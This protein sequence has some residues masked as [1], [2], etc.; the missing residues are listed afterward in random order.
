MSDYETVNV[1]RRGAAA[2]IELNRPEALN[3][4]NKRL[5]VH[6]RAAIAELADDASAPR[7]VGAAARAAPGGI[8]PQLNAWLFE[9]M[10]GQ[11]EREAQVQ[12]EMAA[13]DDFL[14][15]VAAFVEKRPTR[16]QGR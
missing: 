4:W 15:G 2:T 6:L 16:F 11:L 13:S 14:E 10:D 12:G 3:A 8:K 9:R 1:H 5:G 7:R